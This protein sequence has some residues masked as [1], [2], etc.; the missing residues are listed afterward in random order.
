MIDACKTVAEA[1][2]LS[3]NGQNMFNSLESLSKPVV[4]AISGS[5]LGGGLEVSTGDV[6]TL[7][8]K[9]ALTTFL[10]H[11]SCDNFLLNL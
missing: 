3:R 9:T 5:C 1:T 8:Q 11:K 7:L 10:F 6:S 2:D 4:A